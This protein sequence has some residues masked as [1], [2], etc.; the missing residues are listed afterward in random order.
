[1]VAEKIIYIEA[2]NV[3]TIWNIRLE[4]HCGMW[5]LKYRDYIREYVKTFLGYIGVLDM[6]EKD[7]T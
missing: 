4:W 3:W 2:K 1:M 5:E 6:S 7:K